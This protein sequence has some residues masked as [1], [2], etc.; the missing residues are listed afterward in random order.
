MRPQLQHEALQF[1]RHR[2]Q[3]PQFKER[4]K[5]RAGIEGT[6]SQ[7]VRAFDLRKTRYIGLAKTHLQHLATAAA[8]NLSRVVA[9]LSGVPKAKT[10]RSTFAALAPST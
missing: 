6:I 4:Y 7:A 3:Q 2:Q 8:V 9:W 1:G 5:T 10:R